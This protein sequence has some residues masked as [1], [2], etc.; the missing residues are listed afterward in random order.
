MSVNE[1]LEL[2]SKAKGFTVEKYSDGYEVTSE[3]ENLQAFV[4][5]V[6]VYHR[7][8]YYVTDV[9]KV[10]SSCIEINM[11]ELMRL[12]AFCEEITKW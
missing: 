11:E 4:K 7:V 10:T 2:L 12:K 3:H 1:K 6:G 9:Q 5:E 8:E